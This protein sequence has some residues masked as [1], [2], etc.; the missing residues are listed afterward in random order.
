MPLCRHQ[1]SDGHTNIGDLQ[2]NEGGTLRHEQN[3]GVEIDAVVRPHFGATLVQLRKHPLQALS[4][5]LPRRPNLRM[6]DQ[7]SEGILSFHLHPIL[8][9]ATV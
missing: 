9:S 3:P 6:S 1:L 8:E 4:R 5:S 2:A 7:L